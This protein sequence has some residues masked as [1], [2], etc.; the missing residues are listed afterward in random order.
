MLSGARR[1]KISLDINDYRRNPRNSQP[2]ET[3]D[4]KSERRKQIRVKF[5][6]CG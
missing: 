6:E 3:T 5:S 2:G 1:E 4:E